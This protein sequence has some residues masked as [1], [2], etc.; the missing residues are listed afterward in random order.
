M[1]NE[2]FSNFKIEPL[3]AFINIEC[4]D[5]EQLPYEGYIN[6]SIRIRDGLPEAEPR[7]WLF[8]FS[9]DTNHSATTPVILGTNILNNC[10]YKYRPH[11]L[12]KA[13]GKV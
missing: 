8:L 2:H 9:P 3:K 4:A 5:G 6:L 12:Q 1:I 10:K 7:Q 13:K 11:L